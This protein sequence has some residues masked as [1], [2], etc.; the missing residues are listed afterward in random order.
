M[1]FYGTIQQEELS[2]LKHQNVSRA[3]TFGPLMVNNTHEDGSSCYEEAFE[4]DQ[5]SY[6]LDKDKGSLRL[7]TKQV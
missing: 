4:I 6:L 7:S 1:I 3:L 2:V 5:Q